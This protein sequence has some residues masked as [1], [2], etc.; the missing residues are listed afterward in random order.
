M[1]PLPLARRASY[2]GTVG[3]RRQLTAPV[4]DLTC[5]PCGRTVP[6]PFTHGPGEEWRGQAH[7]VQACGEAPAGSEA[8]RVM[9]HRAGGPTPTDLQ[10]RRLNGSRSW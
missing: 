10:L 8:Q 5:L 9:S 1:T 6:S 3:P 2:H 7:P 4:P